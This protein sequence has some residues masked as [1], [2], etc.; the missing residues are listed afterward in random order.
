M[1]DWRLTDQKTYLAGKTLLRAVFHPSET[2]DHEHCSF[3]W[4][5]LDKDCPQGYC[6]LD[7]YHWICENCFQDFRGDFAWTVSPE[8]NEW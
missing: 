3:C 1:N 5:K 6:T 8:R 4:A 2:N 7:R